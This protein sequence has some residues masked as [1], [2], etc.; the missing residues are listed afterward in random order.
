VSFVHFDE[1]GQPCSRHAQATLEEVMF[2]A[3]IGSRAQGFHHD[4][5]SKLQGLMMS[6][7]EIGELAEE[8]DPR[9]AAATQGAHEALREILGLLNAN[10][11][12]TKPAVRARAQLRDVL[13]AACKRVYVTLAGQVPDAGLE[14][15]GP[16][17]IHALSLVFDVAAGPGRGRTLPVTAQIL[18][19]H[20]ELSLTASTTPPANT[21]E[22]LAIATY[23]LARENGELRCSG[24]GA[25]LSVR[26]PVTG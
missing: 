18:D 3:T 25:R 26:L 10:R 17:T 15:S 6:L 21:A 11:A 19:G 24:D 12:L 4:V 20:V 23:V 14:V 9:I 13:G 22:S 1:H 8:G 2:L 16:S 5:A 7:D